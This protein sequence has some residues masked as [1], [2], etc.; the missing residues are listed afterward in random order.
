MDLEDIKK[1][2]PIQWILALLILL[3][4]HGL[5]LL[6]SYYQFR[7]N[8]PSA[9]IGII[10]NPPGQVSVQLNNDVT[11]QANGHDG[12]FGF[13]DLQR[14]EHHL[15]FYKDGY[16]PL[17]VA[18]DLDDPLDNFLERE[19]EM[20]PIDDPRG[21]LPMQR[22]D[23]VSFNSRDGAQPYGAKTIATSYFADLPN[24]AERIG[25]VY[26]GSEDDRE[27]TFPEVDIRDVRSLEGR[28]IEASDT[29]L[30]WGS[31]PEKQWLR[32]FRMGSLEGVVDRGSTIR[33]SDRVEEIGDGHYWAEVI[34]ESNE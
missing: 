25:W 7:W 4:T 23:T 2:T 29:V 11:Q 5:T 28:S 21:P 18:T 31:A 16:H 33:F 20:L 9:L 14:G 17:T 13:R 3:I 19:I 15:Y 26:I 12:W 24:I 22:F 30:V 34:I 32:D 6:I 1:I 27:A 10:D 8:S